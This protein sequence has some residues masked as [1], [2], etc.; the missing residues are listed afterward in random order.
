MRA[1]LMIASLGVATLLLGVTM[2]R[3]SPTAPAAVERKMLQRVPIE[4]SDEELQMI[5]VTYPPGAESTPH[6]HP[7]PGMNYIVEGAVESQYQGGPLEHYKTGDS[8]LDQR[9]RVHAIF[10]NTS[11]TAP[12]RFLIACKIRK[13]VSFKQDV[14]PHPSK[15]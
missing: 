11:S 3:A 10:R 12:L 5:L 8:Y 1:R 4:G 7:V 15:P 14:P 9:D 6:V 2:S 13:G